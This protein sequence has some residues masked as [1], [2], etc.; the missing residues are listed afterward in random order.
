MAVNLSFI[1]FIIPKSI[2][3]VKYVG[4]FNK[5]LNDH[6]KS[7]GGS[8]YFDK[9]LF[10]NGAMSS[11]G[12][13]ILIDKWS[14]LGFEATDFCVVESLLP[15][16]NNPCEWLIIN[17]DE[18]SA[19]LVGTVSGPI[20]GRRLFYERRITR[21][22]Q[23]I[24]KKDCCRMRWTALLIYRLGNSNPALAARMESWLAR[25]LIWKP[26]PSIQ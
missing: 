26:L 3:E 22:S 5:C 7:I 10:H 14:A 23:S 1:D 11:E 6:R 15:Q 20:V 17:H 18:R 12:I 21:E 4:G 13:N 19:H 25:Q 9:N 2:I 24:F 16:A 8:V